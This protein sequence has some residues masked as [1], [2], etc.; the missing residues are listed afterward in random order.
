MFVYL[1]CVCEG[2]RARICI[3]VDSMCLLCMYVRM[4]VEPLANINGNVLLSKRNLKVCA[5]L[6]AHQVMKQTHAHLHRAPL[7]SSLACET[8]VALWTAFE[9]ASA[10]C[11]RM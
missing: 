4:L 9:I 5:T 7:W 1:F 6:H 10:S 8:R 11:K 3:F 2:V